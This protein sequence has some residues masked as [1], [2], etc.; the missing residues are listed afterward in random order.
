MATGASILSDMFWYGVVFVAAWLIFLVA[1]VIGA[2]LRWV[3][4]VDRRLVILG[5][6]S[7][8]AAGIVSWLF[9]EPQ[10]SSIQ[11]FWLATVTAPIAFLG[12]CGIFI[13]IGPANVDRSVTLSMMMAI[14]AEGERGLPEQ[15][16]VTGPLGL[17]FAKRI[18]E[19]I[20]Y[21]VV[22]SAGDNVLL[23]EAGERTRQFYLWLGRVFNIRPQ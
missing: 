19:L 12:F 5:N 14:A 4:N 8:L 13:L 21:G 11:V 10:F 3:E 2:R 1:Y 16:L 6:L 17:I 15:A 22:V 23:S 20:G 9:L 7:A 18:R